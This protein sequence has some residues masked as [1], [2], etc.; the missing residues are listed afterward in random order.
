MVIAD[1]EIHVERHG[2]GLPDFGPR[3]LHG[4]SDRRRLRTAIVTGRHYD[5]PN[6]PK[7]VCVFDRADYASWLDIDTDRSAGK[8]VL[9]LHRLNLWEIVYSIFNS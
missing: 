5:G 2:T 6:R 1:D 7:T 3:V 9:Y 4:N 8:D